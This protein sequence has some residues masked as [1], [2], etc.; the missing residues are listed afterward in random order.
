MQKLHEE[1]LSVVEIREYID[2]EYSKYAEPTP[3]PYPPG[4]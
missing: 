2:E 3:T 4:H 1:G